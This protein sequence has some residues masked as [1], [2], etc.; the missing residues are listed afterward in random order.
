MNRKK[1]IGWLVSLLAIIMP[2]L[3]WLSMMPWS[4]RFFSPTTILTSLGQLAGLTGMAMFAVTLILISRSKWLEKMFAGLNTM[5]NYHHVFGAISFVLLLLHPIFLAT[6]YW[7]FSSYA[8]ALFLLPSKNWEINFGIFGLLI[9]IMAIVLTFF[10]KLIYEH[11]RFS[12][13]FLGLAFFLG[14]LHAF[15]VPT[16][17]SRSIF[18]KVYMLILCFAALLIYIYRSLLQRWLVPKYEYQVVDI[19]K[20][21][22]EIVEITLAPETKNI[23]FFPGQFVFAEFDQ[24]KLSSEIHPFSISSDAGQENIK[25]AIKYLGDYSEGLDKL[26]VGAMAKLEGPFG[27]FSYKYAKYKQQIWIGGGIGITPILS[28]A[29]SLSVDSDLKIVIFYCVKDEAEAVFLRELKKIEKNNP[30]IT[31]LTNYSLTQGHLTAEKLQE[32]QT[33]KLEETDVF[34]CGPKDMMSGLKRQ[35]TKSYVPE[36][37]IHNEEFTMY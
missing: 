15:L 22:P 32:N 30:A 1:N 34:I 6:K 29:R 28:M 14:G 5:Y 2:G 31:V 21:G 4:D 8:A 7:L 9:M 35:L 18:L 20:F 26:K 3:I 27:V 25:L 13:K 17:I 19:T 10:G 37:Q 23:S 33:A 36:E 12:H 11:W 24:A 16:D